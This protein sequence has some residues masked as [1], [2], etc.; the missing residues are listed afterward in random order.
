MPV[1]SPAPHR[2][3]PERSNSHYCLAADSTKNSRLLSKGQGELLLLISDYYHYYTL[4]T[5]H[6]SNVF[7]LSQFSKKY[8]QG[9]NNKWSLSRNINTLLVHMYNSKWIITIKHTI[10]LLTFLASISNARSLS[11]TC[12]Y[13]RRRAFNT[14]SE[15][16]AFRSEPVTKIIIIIKTH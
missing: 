9:D 16:R 12:G 15:H 14:D 6:L 8:S 10:K 5:K 1:V 2:P 13:T 4:N 7:I 3:K 11:Y